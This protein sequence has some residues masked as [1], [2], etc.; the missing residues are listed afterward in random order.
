[1]PQIVMPTDKKLEEVVPLIS[2]S[3]RVVGRQQ[4]CFVMAE[5]GVNHNGDVALAHKLIDAAAE[6]RVDAIKF[7]TFDP[8]KLAAPDAPKAEYQ[9]ENTARRETNW[10]CCRG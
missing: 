5:A 10:K 8:E 7:Q 6:A 4:P 2:I 1:M 9:V 3:R